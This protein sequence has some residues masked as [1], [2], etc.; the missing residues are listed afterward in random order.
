MLGLISI[1]YGQEA[2]DSFWD[3]GQYQDSWLSRMDS[4]CTWCSPCVLRWGCLSL[5]CRQTY[6]LLITYLTCTLGLSFPLI[7]PLLTF[8][9]PAYLHNLISASLLSSCVF[10]ISDLWFMFSFRLAESCCDV[11]SFRCTSASWFIY[12]ILLA[13]HTLILHNFR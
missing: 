8:Y 6:W 7:L 10:A 1:E 12:S 2:L 5:P 4:F 13:L 3:S 9:I 11:S